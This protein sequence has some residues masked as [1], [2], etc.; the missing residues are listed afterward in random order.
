V[1][2]L[3]A[4][5][6]PGFL[7]RTWPGRLLIVGALIKLLYVG[8]ALFGWST[9][10]VV[11]VISTMGGVAL[12]VAAVLVLYRLAQATRRN[13]LWRVRRKLTVSY[14][15][16]GV[17]PVILIVGFFLL[18]GRLLFNNLSSYLIQ[19]SFREMAAEGNA[20]ARAVALERTHNDQDPRATEAL[21][22]YVEQVQA[23]YPGLA[24]GFVIDAEHRCTSEPA[25]TALPRRYGDWAHA[26]VPA[27]IPAWVKCSGF[28]GV[29]A[30][31]ALSTAGTQTAVDAVV[32]AVVYTRGGAV[33]VDLPFDQ[34][35]RARME[36]ATGVA[37]GGFSYDGQSGATLA[38]RPAGGAAA[39][40]AGSA[41]ATRMMQFQWVAMLDHVDWA[42][43]RTDP[44]Q[45]QIGFSVRD[46]Y[47]RL[48]ASQALLGDF[49]GA[50]LMFIAILF[51]IIE[52]GALAM[53]VVLARSITGSIHELFTGTE[54]VRDGDFGHRISVRVNDQLGAL[55]DS[56][57]SM[58]G[59]IEDLLRQAAE[60]RR[61]EE[62][63]R[64][65]REIQT[66]LLPPGPLSVP[67]MAVSTMCVPARE[68]GGDYYDVIALEGGRVGVL[69]ADVSGKGMSA[70]LYMAELKGLMLSL[71]RIYQSP[72]DLLIAANRLISEHVDSRSFI[73]MTYAVIDPAAGTMVYARAG[74]TP[75][76]H[77]PATFDGESEAS[78]LT[79]D[80]MVVGLRLDNG[81]RFESLLEEA[82]LTLRPGDLLVFFTDGISEAMNEES[83]CFGE[84]RLAHL[85]ETHAHM[86][87]DELRERV[88]R[89]IDAFVG[90]AP[91]HD[92]M[93]MILLKVND[94]SC[95]TQS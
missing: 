17:V 53:G 38:T 23:L 51:L 41:W 52:I 21:A 40:A 29:L 50:L 37:V 28:S 36:L 14:I 11:R 61:L 7:R 25:P 43:G 10:G 1:T 91:Q 79:P 31:P 77:V 34:I 92:D 6:I 72:R 22:D 88:L 95:Q 90:G 73:T 60:K 18:A 4:G 82:T 78:I 46:I 74:H 13:L 89:E 35:V 9:D 39:D 68:V 81:E 48:S 49:L 55:A 58:T 19:A 32:R 94:N 57:N 20:I 45:V 56:F 63:M 2:P 87:F 84:P 80:G 3:Y 70:A 44:L 26:P 64:L 67:G 69:I 76:I 93:T 12:A 16:I 65:A 8:L 83:E 47:N 66:S 42:T 59:S 27:T 24:V 54:R 30:L 15:F 5:G 85:L 33:V 62:E 71:H 75:L 86:P